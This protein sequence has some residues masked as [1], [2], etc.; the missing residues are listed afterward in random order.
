MESKIFEIELTEFSFP[1][2]LKNEHANFR[3]LV[4]LRFIDDKGEPKVVHAVLPSLANYWECATGKSN[5][6][7]YVRGDDTNGKG[8]FDVEKKVDDWDKTI[9]WVRGQNLKTIRFKVYDV[10]REDWWNKF[11]NVMKAI[12]EALKMFWGPA[13]GVAEEVSSAL[14]EEMFSKHKL[15]F[16][17]ATNLKSN[18]DRPDVTGPANVTG[19]GVL[20]SDYYKEN[21][22][23]EN[24]IYEIK[25]LID[26]S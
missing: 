26:D 15:L 13:G 1:K 17:G 16:Q 22:K 12:P 2:E 19:P 14:I 25:F 3:F 9:F 10:N 23:D 21:T 7:N 8:C 5:Q 20:V 4:D 18:S 24:I 11:A 6:P